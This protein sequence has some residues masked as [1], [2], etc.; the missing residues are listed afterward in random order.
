MMPNVSNFNSISRSHSRSRSSS[1][2][3]PLLS[4]QQIEENSEET[5]SQFFATIQDDFNEINK[6]L[7]NNKS[8]NGSSILETEEKYCDIR[9]D[10]NTKKD[11]KYLISQLINKDK[12]HAI[13]TRGLCVLFYIFYLEKKSNFHHNFILNKTLFKEFMNWLKEKCP[14]DYINQNHYSTYYYLIK[15]NILLKER[16]IEDIMSTAEGLLNFHPVNQKENILL[17]SIINKFIRQNPYSSYIPQLQIIVDSD[18]NADI[19]SLQSQLSEVERIKWAHNE[20]NIKNGV[21]QIIDQIIE[22]Y[23]WER[24]GKWDFFD[25][26][27]STVRE[28]SKQEDSPIEYQ[29]LINYYDTSVQFGNEFFSLETNKTRCGAI[30]SKIAAAQYVL[31]MLLNNQNKNKMNII[32]SRYIHTFENY[33]H[34]LLDTHIKHIQEV[35]QEITFEGKIDEVKLKSLIDIKEYVK[36]DKREIFTPEFFKNMNA[37]PI[38]FIQL[39]LSPNNIKGIGYGFNDEPNRANLKRVCEIF[40]EEIEKPENNLDNNGNALAK[41]YLDELKQITK[42]SFRNYENKSKDVFL[43]GILKVIGLTL[44]CLIFLLPILFSTVYEFLKYY[45]KFGH[46]L[47][48]INSAFNTAAKAIY[49]YHPKGEYISGEKAYYTDFLITCLSSLCGITTSSGCKSNK[50]RGGGSQIPEAG[51]PAVFCYKAHKAAGQL[52]GTEFNPQVYSI[53]NFKL[54]NEEER[55]LV[56]R[57]FKQ[58]IP[59]RVTLSNTGIPGSKSLDGVNHFTEQAFPKEQHRYQIKKSL[60]GQQK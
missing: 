31:M 30:H 20:L 17:V 16:I 9:I 2:S 53:L 8:A 10:E 7:N 33:W 28:A 25:T 48:V 23:N 18:P 22:G 50:D 45:F 35:I 3:A 60:R 46:H 36:K 1:L 58:N 49:E 54:Q 52:N 26:A 59:Y 42:N 15:K 34:G 56:K 37:K 43:R 5:C 41:F 4:P 47:N 21:D 51:M 14:Q 57:V 11:S 24:Y 19:P 55:Q 29:S 32:D 38:E 6:H 44:V 13:S 12:N 40:A 39:K 27:P